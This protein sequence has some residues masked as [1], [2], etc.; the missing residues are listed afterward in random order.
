M[1]KT[2]G[3]FQFDDS[4]LKRALAA[5]SPKVDAYVHAVVSYNADRSVAYMKENASWTDRTGAARAGLRAETEWKPRVFHAIHL[6]HMVKY[7]IWL[8]VRFAGK[9]AIILPTIKVYGPATM[10]MLNGLFKKLNS[11]GL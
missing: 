1:A 4:S 3:T 8:E 2:G 11:G 9:Y 6:F 7:G 5:L 10:K